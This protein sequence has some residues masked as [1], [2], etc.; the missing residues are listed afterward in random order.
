MRGYSSSHCA[1]AA[2]AYRRWRNAATSASSSR[3]TASLPVP[4][5]E[6][7]DGLRSG[8]RCCCS[9]RRLPNSA[10]R[11]GLSPAPSLAA[12][13]EGRY[14]WRI[15]D[16]NVDRDFIATAL[17][18]IAEKPMCRRP[19]RDGR[20][21]A[22]HRDRGFEGHSGQVPGG[23]DR[24]GRRIPSNCP[25]A[26]LNAPYVDYVVRA[27]GEETFTDLLEC[28]GEVVTVNSPPTGT[29][30]AARRNGRAQRAAAVHGG[31]SGLEAPL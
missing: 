3:C 19:H 18:I 16:G 20:P 13:L 12:S 31:K 17:R 11:V 14:P 8:V 22:A 30:L 26:A 21:T 27:Q 4:P 24:L 10:M 1:A 25:Q 7:G 15:L 29:E 28:L 23:A 2:M 6:R 5:Q 9:T